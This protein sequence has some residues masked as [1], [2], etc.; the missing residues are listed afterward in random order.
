MS[1][2][3][4]KL[5]F[6]SNKKKFLKIKRNQLLLL[7]TLF[8]DG[9]NI[10]KYT[11]KLNNLRYSEH[12]GY[13]GI[14]NNKLDRVIVSALTSREDS[15]DN[16]ILLPNNLHDTYKYEYFFHTHPSTENLTRVKYGIFYELPSINDIFHFIDH[17]NSGK[18]LGSIVIAP[19]GYYIIYPKNFNIKKIKYDIELEDIIFKKLEKK[20]MNIQNNAIKKYGND[21]TD[22]EF[23]NIIAK[24]KKFLK[25]FNKI[26]NKYL[27]NQIKIILKNRKKDILTNK[28]ILNNLYLP[29]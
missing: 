24:E 23:Y 6:K 5:I 8:N 22:D 28:W 15:D 1:N 18:T 12:S 19:E 9:G 2:I 7:E 20:S 25:N 14:N 13:L 3:I 11:D 26:I 21:F 29:I 10:K 16:E 4:G 27:N 17:Y